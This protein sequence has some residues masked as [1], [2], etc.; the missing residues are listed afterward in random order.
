MAKPTDIL[1]TAVTSDG[2]APTIAENSANTTL[3]GTFGV[4]DADVTTYT[5]TLLDSAGGRF[6]IS[7][8]TLRVNNYL[9][10]D[11]EDQIDHTITVRVTKNSG[12]TFDKAFVIRVTDV[13]N[14]SLTTS[15]RRH[16][17]ERGRQRHLQRCGG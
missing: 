5:Y 4:V 3:I 6:S 9:R 8:N 15:G 17:D 11:F 1:I 14:E 2:A 16:D 10:L 13:L 12:Q 7:G